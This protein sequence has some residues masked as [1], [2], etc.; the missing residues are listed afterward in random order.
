MAAQSPAM[1]TQELVQR[2]LESWPQAL[3]LWS[4]FTKL[5]DPVWCLSEEDE[6]REG[7]TG[8]FAMIRLTD[9]AV[10]ISLRQIEA[11]GMTEFALEILAHE[12]G[13][14]VFA[15][16]NAND[17]LRLLARLRR[18]LPGVEDRTPL[19]ANLYA[20]LLINDRLHR[21]ADLRL[22]EVYR[23]LTGLHVAGHPSKGAELRLWTLYMRA[24]ERLWGLERG[25]LAH[26]RID[27]TLDYDAGLIARLVRGYAKDWL[28]GAGRFAAVCLPYLMEDGE[29]SRQEAVPWRRLLDTRDA[30]QGANPT[31]LSEVEDDEITGAVHPR[32]EEL[33]EIT[34]GVEGDLSGKTG[35]NPAG[36]TH[37]AGE[38]HRQPSEYLELFKAA[39]INMAPDEAAYRYYRE[40][41]LPHLIPFPAKV[42]PDTREPQLEG[43]DPWSLGDAAEAIDWFESVLVSPRVVPGYTTKQRH[44][45]TAIGDQPE[46]RPVDL[47]LGIDCSGSMVNPR[48]NISY[49]VLG[50]TIMALSALRAGARVMA[51][52]S[53]DPGD[54]TSTEGF[55]R[56]E[57]A[58]MAILT[59]YL[60]TGYAFGIPRLNKTFAETR[61]T[62]AHILI[63][64]DGDIFSML[65]EGSAKTRRKGKVVEKVSRLPG[66]ESG[67]DIAERSLKAA[68]G[69]G[70][71]LLHMHEGSFKDEVKRL[72]AQGWAVH[73]VTDWAEVVAF[74]RAFARTTWLDKGKRR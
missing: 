61:P 36:S 3:A 29:K 26:G 32:D 12:I 22:P 53:G 47:Y 13:H 39:G 14:H 74:A 67:W 58:V 11:S 28:S 8:S 33:A 9:H 44:M 38:H 16:A 6:K 71:M 56:D 43:L 25:D 62:P 42:Q 24:Y 48:Y 51:V 40:R 45:E 69:A 37:P 5:Q 70:T 65:E 21:L 73:H 52:L 63:I 64:S 60:G 27:P 20:D 49:P 23:R 41:A 10:V 66:S 46:H 34:D 59:G 19:I 35:R 15:P 1:V 4:R 31:G 72:R 2:W 17:H 7:L 68:G 50:G 54:C 30:G 18:G 55:I 57:R